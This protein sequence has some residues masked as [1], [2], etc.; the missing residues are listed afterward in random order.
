MAL[1][2]MSS[3]GIT[4]LSGKAGGSVYA[5]N[6]GG[7]YIRNFAVPSNPQTAAQSAAR[8]AFGGFASQ[9]RALTEEQRN[10]WEQATESF[11]YINRFGDEKRMSGENLFISLNRNL[12]IVG[13]SSISAPPAPAGVDGVN[14]LEVDAG[15]TS[16]T[17]AIELNVAIN[18][19]AGADTAYAVYA[20]PLLSPGINYVKNRMR[21]V[22]V[23]S[24]AEIEQLDLTAN[25]STIFGAPTQAGA[26]SVRVE[27]INDTTGER[28]AGITAK[29]VLTITP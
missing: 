24:E 14:L 23:A 15:I 17:F 10:A 9:W 19:N 7:S 5:H 22:T 3:I 29:G 21:L 20:T 11:P 8:A 16:G 12:E 1:I 18:I 2:K 26:I 6:R 27:P 28:G 25:Y 13:T 4:N